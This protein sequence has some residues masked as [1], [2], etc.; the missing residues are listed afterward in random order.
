MKLI[1]AKCAFVHL[2]GFV[3]ALK[4]VSERSM[5]ACP[6]GHIVLFGI[7]INSRRKK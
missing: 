6:P 3:A 1:F 2:R 4:N 7:I 5:N